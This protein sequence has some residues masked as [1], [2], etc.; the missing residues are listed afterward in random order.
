MSTK[1]IDPHVHFFN[2]IEGQYLW[3]QGANPPTWPNLDKIKQQISAEQL[4]ESTDFELSGLVHIEAGF[5]NSAPINELKWLDKH[6]SNIAYKAISFIQIDQDSE[7]FE[8]T[9]KNLIHPTL[10]GIRDIT[11]GNDAARLLN[12]FCLDNLKILSHLNLHFEAQLELENIPIVKK[13]AYYAKQLPHLQIVINHA[14]LPSNI[15]LWQQ[16]I[17]LLAKNCNVAIKF[18]GFELLSLNNQQQITCFDIIFQHF[19]EQ[20][21]MFASNFPV[22]QI[23]S[24]YNNLWHAHLGL[25]NSDHIW[26]HLS[27]KNAKH[28]YLV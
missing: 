24:S 14:G 12:S 21:I 2:L 23:N 17:E 11:E 7:S 4:I 25:C 10:A 27:Y 22:C 28:L 8:R 20:R 16:G 9:L 19:G 13:L 6:L 15:V 26:H 5:D 18:S 3:L 1:I